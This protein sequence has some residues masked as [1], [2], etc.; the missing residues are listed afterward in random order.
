MR[1]ARASFCL[2]SLFSCCACLI[3]GLTG[4]ADVAAGGVCANAH[5][6]K[7]R[8]KTDCTMVF[9]A[10]QIMTHALAV[11]VKPVQPTVKCAVRMKAVHRKPGNHRLNELHELTYL[12]VLGLGL[13]QY[14]NICIGVFP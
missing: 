8:T 3:W 12:L 13:P 1:I 6:D 10:G 5:V 11:V 14:R 2:P 9:M 7:A 4:T